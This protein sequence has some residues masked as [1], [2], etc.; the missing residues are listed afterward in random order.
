MGKNFDQMSAWH[1]STMGKVF[2]LHE[3][4][5]V[6]IPGIPYYFL[7]PPGVIPDL[8]AEHHHQICSS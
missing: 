1:N 3:A 4:E 7:S 8:K 6:S 2:A 5:L